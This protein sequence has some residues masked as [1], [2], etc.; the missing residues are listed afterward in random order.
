MKNNVNANQLLGVQTFF[1]QH[2]HNSFSFP[3]RKMSCVIYKA[4]VPLGK[5]Q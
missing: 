5:Y 3:N 1:A 4:N 2:W